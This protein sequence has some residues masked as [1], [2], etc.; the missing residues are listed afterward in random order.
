[1]G[2]LQLSLHST[3]DCNYHYISY[4][5]LQ[6]S[7][8]STP[9]GTLPIDTHARVLPFCLQALKLAGV[10]ST[11]V[12]RHTDDAASPPPLS[13]AL[14]SSRPRPCS[15]NV[16]RTGTRQCSQSPQPTEDAPEYAQ[17]TCEQPGAGPP[18]VRCTFSF[19]GAGLEPARSV[20]QPFGPTQAD[21][22]C[23]ASGQAN[24][25]TQDSV[26]A[27]QGEQQSDSIGSPAAEFKRLF[28]QLVPNASLGSLCGSLQQHTLS[29]GEQGPH[30]HSTNEGIPLDRVAPAS[31]SGTGT[32]AQVSH[33]AEPPPGVHAYRL[34]PEPYNVR[35]RSLPAESEYDEDDHAPDLSA[36][37]SSTASAKER[38]PGDLS[39]ADVEDFCTPRRGHML[40]AG[41]PVSAHCAG[42]PQSTPGHDAAALEASP[43]VHQHLGGAVARRQAQLGPSR[44]PPC[45]PADRHGWA[46]AVPC[47]SSP[48]HQA[49]PGANSTAP[50]PQPR[51]KDQQVP[52]GVCSTQRGPAST[53]DGCDQQVFHPGGSPQD[54][55]QQAQQTQRGK[56]RAAE[57]IEH[58]HTLLQMVRKETAAMREQNDG[59]LSVLEQ[60]R[61]LSAEL[62]LRCTHLENELAER[63][64]TLE[65]SASKLV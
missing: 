12:V 52:V 48:L 13:E 36:P 62:Q 8:H 24:S 29:R 14:A 42:T 1:M 40:Q 7:L 47:S 60:E 59:L 22:S 19:G 58:G 25:H 10:H 56:H 55:C 34:S 9:D 50:D 63:G 16:T 46:S 18:H 5:R 53:R 44:A 31:D 54:L 26:S 61:K 41:S 39:S 65:V 38:L 4:T 15:T 2:H 32:A 35:A 45:V 57:E 6:L 30:L 33:C 28:D 43:V 21:A 51:C 49:R 23:T 3:P 17:I 20:E 27:L 64:A 11:N 37:A